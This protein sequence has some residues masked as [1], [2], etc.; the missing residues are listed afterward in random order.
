[1]SHHHHH[2]FGSNYPTGPSFGANEQTLRDKLAERI[3]PDIADCLVNK[4]TQ[5]SHFDPAQIERITRTYGGQYD[6]VFDGIALKRITAIAYRQADTWNRLSNLPGETLAQSVDFV[7]WNSWDVR[8]HYI[9]D[10]IY[11]TGEA[12][13]T[14][15]PGDVGFRAAPGTPGYLGPYTGPTSR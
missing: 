10:G 2:H 13:A 3:G 5:G 7:R 12:G 8:G 4:W 6:G 9:T 14:L 11:M 15:N 1:M